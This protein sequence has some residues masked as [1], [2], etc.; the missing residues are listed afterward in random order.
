MFSI[1][2]METARLPNQTMTWRGTR[3]TTPIGCATVRI[4]KITAREAPLEGRRIFG[5]YELL[6]EISRGSMG[7]VWKARQLSLNRIVALK[8][9]S[10]GVL[11]TTEDVAR[12]RAEAETVAG[13]RHP[14]VVSIYEIGEHEGV[15]FFSMDYVEGR[16]LESMVQAA[17]LAPREAARILRTVAEAVHFMH[18]HDVMHRDIKPL[19]IIM[20]NWGRPVLLDFGIARDLSS[21]S[22]LTQTGVVMGSPCYMAPEQAERTSENI[23]PHTEVHALGV[24]LYQ[25]ITGAV[26]YSGTTAEETLMNVVRWT[27]KPPTELVP[28][29]PYDLETIVL[30][31]LEKSPP[32]RYTTAQ[33]LADDLDRFLNGL[34]VLA[35][36]AKLGRRVLTWLEQH[37]WTLFWTTYT[38]TNVFFAAAF[39]LWEKTLY[40]S[41]KLTQHTAAAI[42]PPLGVWTRLTGFEFF[43]AMVGMVLCSVM[44]RAAAYGLRITDAIVRPDMMTTRSRRAVP[45]YVLKLSVFVALV[46]GVQGMRSFMGFIEI[47]I[48]KQTWRWEQLVL[49]T[50]ALAMW[51]VGLLGMVWRFYR[52]QHL[53]T[54]IPN[55][56]SSLPP[57]CQAAV[58]SAIFRG[59]KSHAVAL[60]R[61]ATEMD[62]STAMLCVNG[63]TKHLREA[64]PGKFRDAKRRPLVVSIYLS[65]MIAVCAVVPIIAFLLAPSTWQH[66]TLASLLGIF[67]GITLMD[68]ENWVRKPLHQAMLFLACAAFLGRAVSMK[69]QLCLSDDLYLWLSAGIIAGGGVVAAATRGS[70]TNE[71][72]DG[73]PVPRTV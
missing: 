21:K 38:T 24:T 72:E 29:I 20:D 2:K 33:D 17:P 46:G 60:C 57:A 68:M 58:Q 43:S 1:T 35:R 31:C 49:E 50:Y 5:D 9:V 16:T 62:L 48:W 22:R 4:S 61:E 6:N 54:P 36:R 10:A 19:N 28:T 12:F 51:S 41:S 18:M 37:P 70:K 25:L 15:Q 11:A 8:A 45:G 71:D 47:G 63:L 32:R 56:V 53:G 34:P 55:E 3:A 69:L 42:E 67:L 27:P 44:I 52:A 73:P 7:V 14:N 13:I 30:K 23:G 64:Y 39:G 66:A 26:P 40:L 59:D 65:A